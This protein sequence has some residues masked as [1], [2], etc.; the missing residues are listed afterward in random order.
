MN[1]LNEEGYKQSYREYF[2]P[3][4]NI[5]SKGYLVNDNY[6]GYWVSYYNNGNIMY[7]GNYYNGIVKGYWEWHDYFSNELINK[8][9]FL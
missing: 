4:G 6:H 5:S 7:K 9:F 2:Y 8:E 1:G 3:N